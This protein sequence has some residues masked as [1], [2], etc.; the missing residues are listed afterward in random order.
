MKHYY[1]D[2]I[3]KDLIVI[4]NADKLSGRIDQ[5]VTRIPLAWQE[6]DAMKSGTKK[7]SA[8][9]SGKVKVCGGCKKEGHSKWHCPDK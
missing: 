8:A 3:S 9:G 7:V 4:E 5:H 1:I 6:E 2:T